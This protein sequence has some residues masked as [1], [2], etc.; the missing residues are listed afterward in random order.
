MKTTIYAS[1]ETFNYLLNVYKS[2]HGS[3]NVIDIDEEKF[4]F[5]VIGKPNGSLV[6]LAAY[7]NVY[8]TATE[9]EYD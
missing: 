6:T 3:D 7:S 1:K 5:T 4:V 8:L 2:L 9:R